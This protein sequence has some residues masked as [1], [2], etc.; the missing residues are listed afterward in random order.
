MK[1]KKKTSLRNSWN[2]LVDEVLIYIFRASAKHDPTTEKAYDDL[3]G[4]VQPLLYEKDRETTIEREENRETG[5]E[6]KGSQYRW[7]IR[8]IL[9]PW[10]LFFFRKCPTNL[11]SFKKKKKKQTPSLCFLPFQ[12]FPFTTWF[13]LITQRLIFPK[14]NRCATLFCTMHCRMILPDPA[15][16]RIISH[17]RASP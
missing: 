10:S 3:A 12:L 5:T 15:H 2:L 8:K 14:R 1:T 4:P 7:D 11:K 16:H 17:C 6:A 13:S 9:I